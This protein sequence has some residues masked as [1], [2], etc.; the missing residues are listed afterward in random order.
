MKRALFITTDKYPNGDAGAVRVHAL[1]K[2]LQLIGYEVT[3]VGLGPT[4]NFQFQK[5][6]GVAFISF[7]SSSNTIVSKIKDRLQL[8]KRLEDIYP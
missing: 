3:V 7:R 6:D 8:K 2:I 5:E 1:A 4:T